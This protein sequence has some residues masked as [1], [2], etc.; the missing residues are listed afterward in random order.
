MKVLYKIGVEDLTQSLLCLVAHKT[1]RVDDQSTSIF[2][3]S[4]LKILLIPSTR[5]PSL[6]YTVLQDCNHFINKVQQIFTFSMQNFQKSCTIICVPQSFNTLAEIT[7]LWMLVYKK[8]CYVLVNIFN[9][10]K[11]TQCCVL[12][13]ESGENNRL[14]PL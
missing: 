2:Q 12:I 13:M 14:S 4:I 6:L 1:R 7:Y 10:N 5:L 3:S 9:N 8:S 11:T